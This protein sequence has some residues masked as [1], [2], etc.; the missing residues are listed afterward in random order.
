M[1]KLSEYK[2]GNPAMT[3]GQMEGLIQKI[4]AGAFPVNGHCLEKRG[5]L[6]RDVLVV[7]FGKYPAEHAGMFDKAEKDICLCEIQALENPCQSF[8]GFKEYIGRDL[9]GEHMVTTNYIDQEHNRCL[10]ASKIYGVV[11]AHIRDGVTLWE[12]PLSD[13]PTELPPPLEIRQSD[14]ID[15]DSLKRTYRKEKPACAATQS[16]QREIEQPKLFPYSIQRTIEV[17]KQGALNLRVT[18]YEKVRS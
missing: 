9:F 15:L 14:N 7:A 10:T 18:V 6:H 4:S 8:L 1:I 13:F 11:F 12:R 16:G 17:V 3:V 2:Q 5:I